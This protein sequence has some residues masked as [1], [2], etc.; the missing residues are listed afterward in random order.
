MALAGAERESNARPA[1]QDPGSRYRLPADGE[2]RKPKMRTRPPKKPPRARARAKNDRISALH[3][4]GALRPGPP[5]GSAPAIGRPADRRAISGR[6][7]RR[8][9]EFTPRRGR[10]ATHPLRMFCKAGNYPR[11]PY[12]VL[13]LREECAAIAPDLASSSLFPSRHGRASLVSPPHMQADAS[14]DPARRN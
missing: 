11:S 14:C 6:I 3:V 9:R 7:Q 10:G 13:L 2:V 8:R 5:H 4:K 1:H 12:P